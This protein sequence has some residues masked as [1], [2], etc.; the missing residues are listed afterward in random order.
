M[1]RWGNLPINQCIHYLHSMAPI[2]YSAIDKATTLQKGVIILSCAIFIL[3]LLQ[4]A[5][6]IDRK[7]YDAYADGKILAL[8]GWMSF[9]GGNFIA[10]L[11]WL[12]NPL[13]VAAI[14]SLLNRKLI[15]LYLSILAAIIALSFSLLDSTMTSE[16]G[17]YSKIT[18]L[19]NG[20]KL[21]VLSMIVLAIGTGIN[22]L[23]SKLSKSS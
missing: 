5:F 13:F 7:D 6:Y 3:S 15:G 19:E 17:S 16:S 12:A 2:K 23:V 1:R 11:I 21:W 22:L 8:L 4:P 20:Y 9:L 18:S 14:I 10:S